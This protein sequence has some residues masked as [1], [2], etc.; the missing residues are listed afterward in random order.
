MSTFQGI[1]CLR[2]QSGDEGSAGVESSPK[3]LHS[4]KFKFMKE[5]VWVQ[6]PDSQPT[7]VWKLFYIYVFVKNL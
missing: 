7:K 5:T 3:R 2:Q 1:Y 4:P 6:T